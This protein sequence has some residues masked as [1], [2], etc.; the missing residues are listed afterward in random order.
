MKGASA[1]IWLS[2]APLPIILLIEAAAA[3][4]A[5]V[6]RIVLLAIEPMALPVELS[7]GELLTSDGTPILQGLPASVAITAAADGLSALVSVRAAGGPASLF[8]TALGKVWVLPAN[9]CAAPPVELLSANLKA[10]FPLCA[11]AAGLPA[12]PGA[13]PHEH[14]VVHAGLGQLRP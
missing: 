4:L 13:R 8:D 10:A 11:C 1:L 2:H 7:G 12:L 5:G 14:L 9:A 3:R 6:G